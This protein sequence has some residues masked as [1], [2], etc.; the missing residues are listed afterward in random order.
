MRTYIVRLSPAEAQARLSV[1]D[2]QY[3]EVIPLSLEEIFIYEMGGA[4]NAIHDIL[5]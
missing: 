5:L 4:D 2:P 1:L 3:I